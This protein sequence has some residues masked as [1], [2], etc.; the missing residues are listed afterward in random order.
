MMLKLTDL[1]RKLGDFALRDINL[2]IPEGQ[3]YVL[4]GR[5]GAGKT[6]LL[7]LIAGLEHPDKGSIILD[8]E[9]IT[10]QRIQDRKVGIVFQDYAVFPHMTVFGNIAYP[11]RAR[12]EDKK[13]IT[14]KVEKSASDMNIKH[15]LGRNTE[16]LSGGELQRVA[17]ARTLITSP[18]LLLLDEPLS[19]LDA[20]LKDD[21]KRLLRNLNKTGQT[22]IHVTHDYSDA[23]SLAKR[24]GVI[25]NGRIIQEG[26]VDEVFRNPSNR[27]VA[28][29]AGIRNFFR[30]EVSGEKG[31][32]KGVTKHNVSFKLEG[33]KTCQDCLI[34]VKSDSITLTRKMPE[35]KKLNIIK[36]RISE[37]IPSEFGMEITLDA[38]DLFYVNML[39]SGFETQRF[40]EGEEAWMSFPSKAIIALK[41]IS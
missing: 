16:K 7:E 38:G 35:D 41:G 21:M 6:Q 10:K 15:L 24:V 11:L 4:L 17:L 32:L 26:S 13:S 20:S 8:G 19:S 34:I 40:V 1:N 23:I 5:S 12:K 14:E 39:A 2:E 18:R 3:Y 30:V 31:E 36:G 33:E 25:H 22:I 27:F 37:I 29:Y 9:N 28:R